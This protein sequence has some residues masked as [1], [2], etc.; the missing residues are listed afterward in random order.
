M[1]I[2]LADGDVGRDEVETTDGVVVVDGDLL[3]RLDLD[4]FKFTNSQLLDVV[5]RPAIGKLENAQPGLERGIVDRVFGVIEN[6]KEPCEIFTFDVLE[7]V[8]VAVSRTTIRVVARVRGAELLAEK[9]GF[10]FEK[11]A[12]YPVEMVFRPGQSYHH[13]ADRNPCGGRRE[14]RRATSL[15]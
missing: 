13:H 9:E 8:V 4:F 2:P 15:D 11:V 12:V 14:I 7:G 3:Y 6:P 5:K 10:P 1:L